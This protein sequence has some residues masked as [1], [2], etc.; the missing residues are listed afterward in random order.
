MKNCYVHVNERNR[1]IDE[2]NKKPVAILFANR[3]YIYIYI[4]QCIHTF[5]RSPYFMVSC[6]Q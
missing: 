2:T 4:I 1:N 3:V 5:C 6:F